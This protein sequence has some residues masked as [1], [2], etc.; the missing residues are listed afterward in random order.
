MCCPPTSLS[1][2]TLL[3]M[4]TCARCTITWTSQSDASPT[5]DAYDACPLPISHRMAH[6]DTH[7]HTHMHNAFM[8]TMHDNLDKSIGLL[9]PREMRRIPAHCLLFTGRHIL[10]VA[11]SFIIESPFRETYV[12]PAHPLIFTGRRILYVA[13]SLVFES[14]FREL[15]TMLAHCLIF[16]GRHSLCVALSFLIIQFKI[17]AWCLLFTGWLGFLSYNFLIIQFLKDV[18]DACLLLAI[19]RKAHL[20]SHTLFLSYNFFKKMRII[21]A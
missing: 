19:H 1:A 4:M 12:M 6:L 8:R 16:T 10:C 21:S 14:S 3:R 5:W 15:R 20:V 7:T 11:L 18:H 13:L 17:L 9:P 2:P